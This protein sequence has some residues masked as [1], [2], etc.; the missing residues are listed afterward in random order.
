[1]ADCLEQTAV[2]ASGG[3]PGDDIAIVVLQVASDR[4]AADLADPALPVSQ[5]S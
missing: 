1:V 5:A 2:D 4:S 3:E